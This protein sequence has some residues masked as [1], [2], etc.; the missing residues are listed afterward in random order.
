[1]GQGH[2]IQAKIGMRPKKKKSSRGAASENANFLLGSAFLATSSP[3]I[4]HSLDHDD[5]DVPHPFV[6]HRAYGFEQIWPS[7][8]RS[9][10]LTI[11]H[12]KMRSHNFARTVL[13]SAARNN[14]SSQPQIARSA[15]LNLLPQRVAVHTAVASTFT[16][17]C[18]SSPRAFSS[19]SV[20]L[21]KKS[22]K[23]AFAAVEDDM[24]S[25]QR[26][27][28]DE[29]AQED[30]ED[31]FGGVAD[32]SSAP[33]GS[34]TG[35]TTASMSRVEFAKALEDY[36][37]SL[38]W[39]SIDRGQFP[40]LSRWRNLAGHAIDKQE[41]EALLE[42]AK[43]YRDRVGSLGV[44]SGARFASRA[45]KKRLPELALNAFLD[46]YAYGLE[47]DLES[48]LV[49]QEGLVRKLGRGQREE[50]LAS[51]EIEGAPVQES[52][53][54]GV[55]PSD[56]GA[57]EEGA[58]ADG[59]AQAIEARHE[60]DMPLARAQLSIID[61]MSILTSL[62]ATLSS[63]PAPSPTSQLDPFLVSYLTRAYIQTFRLVADRRRTAT[64]PLLT[65]ILARTDK[66]VSLLTLS[67][68]QSLSSPPAA[69]AVSP[70]QRSAILGRNLSATLSYVA[71]RG[72]DK[73]KD[74]LSGEKLDP[75]R[76]LYRFMDRVDREKSNTLVRKVE[77]LL[78]TYSSL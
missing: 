78:Q 75:V 24:I 47:Y 13:R 62:S 55:V 52:D 4:Q 43:M 53:L 65:Q 18:S 66:L 70:A 58:E 45:S 19:S 54:L 40:S 59:K 69:S 32:V 7:N 28:N 74:P 30:D 3:L 33:S 39:E 36:R 2:V 21:K 8:A 26:E 56:S 71:I 12:N 61:R 48:L 37:A 49:V 41:F 64:N 17:S 27:Q 44:E 9:S 16:T 77:P 42:V 60:L 6:E 31:L 57:S 50:I 1:M 68:Q 72:Q 73:F 25:E 11:L 34:S 46:R 35:T 23:N 63:T 76:T 14:V 20:D 67:A 51:A 38:D 5:D 22:K 29:F 15:S 10:A